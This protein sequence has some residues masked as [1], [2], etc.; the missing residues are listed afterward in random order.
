MAKTPR[1]HR[2]S[3]RETILIVV[4]IIVLVIG[5]YF[6]LVYYPIQSRT[7]ELEAQRIELQTQRAAADVKKAD[8]DRMKA[9]LDE[10]HSGDEPA[11]E[12]PLYNN[13]GQQEVLAACFTTIFSGVDVTITY[14]TPAL[15]GNIYSR[16]V[17][18]TFRVNEENKG[19]EQTVYDKTRSL[20][21]AL[22]HT[23]YRCLMTSLT[24]N[25]GNS[26]DLNGT[27]NVS[28]TVVFYERA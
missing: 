20:L 23:G 4:L 3:L 1:A 18:F 22:L 15:E 19:A 28:T 26:G 10:I 21:H 6:G 8:Y 14:S 24:F 17:Q 25:T 9:A 11:S 2:L 7:T 12:M 5:L 27:V 16:T 13:N